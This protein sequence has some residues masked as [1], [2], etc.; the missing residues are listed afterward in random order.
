[1]SAKGRKKT[2]VMRFEK[3]NE[4]KV[5]AIGGAALLSGHVIYLIMFLILGVTPMVVFNIFSVLFY[6]FLL[7][8]LFHT[9]HR[10]SLVM[11][12]L[13]EIMMH[14]CLGIISLGWHMGFS[15]FLLF[16]MPIPFYMPLKH[17]AVPYLSSL[18]PLTL[19]IVMRTLYSGGR[20]AM[21]SFRDPAINNTIYFLNII[22]GSAILL[23]ISSIHMFN[24]ESMR[25][26]LSSKNESLQKLATIDPLT[27]LFNR[28]AMSEY[29]KLVQHNSERTGKSYAVGIGDID[30]MKKIND[31]YGLTAG[32][33]AIRQTGDIIARAVPAEGYAARW[34][35]EKF[36]FVIPAADGKSGAECADRIRSG[37]SEKV[38][39]T[40]CGPFSVKMTFGIT[41]GAAGEDIQK[42]VSRAEMQ[43]SEGKTHGKDRVV[44]DGR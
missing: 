41:K 22:L 36:L 10:T 28:R 15:V 42:V 44:F 12:S 19:H 29:L 43:L 18:V 40:D 17:P 26:R 1:M 21:Y 11:A 9:T 24:R 16:L 7:F 5:Y 2:D 30:D 3:M 14:A 34:G 27:K 35:G 13:F 38:F 31:I 33:E 23:Y 32:D 25:F 20:S 4:R 37:L 6:S 39:R 8:I